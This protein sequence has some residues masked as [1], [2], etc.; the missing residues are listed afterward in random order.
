M[1]KH[2]AM[3]FLAVIPA[4]VAAQTLSSVSVEPASIRAG[5]SAKRCST[6][7]KSYLRKRRK[8]H[9]QS[10]TQAQWDD[11]GLSREES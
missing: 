6:G 5:E 9:G 3:T 1:M 4:F 2:F 11:F 8:P 7:C 10:G